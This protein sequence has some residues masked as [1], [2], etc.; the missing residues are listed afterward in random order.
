MERLPS[1]I[2]GL[3]QRIEGG[4]PS[5]GIM[6]ILGETGCGKTTF[7]LQS[8]VNAA[9]GGEICIYMT[10]YAEPPYFIRELLSNYN[11]FDPQL[12]EKDLLQLWDLGGSMSHL[13]PRKTLAAIT[14][15]VEESKPS[16]ICIDPIAFNHIFSEVGEYRRFIYDFLMNLRSMN[17]LAMI[18]GEGNLDTQSIESQ[19]A[20]TIIQLY[21]QPSHLDPLKYQNLLHIR[22]MRVTDHSRDMLEVNMSKDGIL[23]KE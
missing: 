11:F 4:I 5:P 6:L 15:I 19:I 18:V 12:M 10:G 17:I 3:D 9:K 20:D 1:G 13:G 23:I 22:K 21:L 2:T 8:L 14:E 16:R 7:G